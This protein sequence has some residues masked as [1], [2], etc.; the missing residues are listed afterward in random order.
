MNQPKFKFGD[1]IK[2]FNS[3]FTVDKIQFVNS[4][5]EYYYYGA[6][7]SNGC[8][9]I[10]ESSVELYTEPKP[11][12]KVYE[13]LRDNLEIS[14]M[15]LTEDEAKKQ[16]PRDKVLVKLCEFEIEDV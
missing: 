11:K 3:Y 5:L 6:G 2:S 16:W 14:G 8:H 4:H 13:W 1:K 9:Y 10:K 15:L 7:E 12:K